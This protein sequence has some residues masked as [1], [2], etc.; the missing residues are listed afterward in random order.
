MGI[1]MGLFG[2]K[3]VERFWFG[4]I[5]RALRNLDDYVLRGE[6]SS[7]RINSKHRSRAND[8]YRRYITIT[9]FVGHT[10]IL[11]K[12]CFLRSFSLPRGIEDNAYAKS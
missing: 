12:L 2:R 3:F 1:P 8:R 4:R 7:N 11:Q 5:C 6:R 10:K 9:L